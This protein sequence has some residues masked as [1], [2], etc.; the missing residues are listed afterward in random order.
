[1]LRAKAHKRAM[2][3]GHRSEKMVSSAFDMTPAPTICHGAKL[4]AVVTVLAAVLSSCGG[5]SAS[6][7][8]A[9]AIAQA[10]AEQD[11]GASIDVHELAHQNEQD[12]PG[13]DEQ[14]LTSRADLIVASENTSRACQS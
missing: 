14:L 4:A 2:G 7:C 1:M 11:W 13:V 9:A 3:R 8:R 6:E 10:E 5:V 12:H